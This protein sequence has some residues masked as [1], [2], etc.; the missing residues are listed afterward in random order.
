MKGV[1]G[2]FRVKR[3]LRI[4]GLTR[5]RKQARE[6]RREGEREERKRDKQDIQRV[7]TELKNR[8]VDETQTWYREED[9]VER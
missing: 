8:E 6:R 5:R 2:V 7:G 1:Q 4:L 9:L 3:G